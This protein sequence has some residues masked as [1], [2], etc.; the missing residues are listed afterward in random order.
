MLKQFLIFRSRFVQ[1]EEAIILFDH[2]NS[3][4][5]IFITFHTNFNENIGEEGKLAFV[6][7]N[8]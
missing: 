7:K 5:T 3:T 2:C 8:N 6:S 1:T 4:N